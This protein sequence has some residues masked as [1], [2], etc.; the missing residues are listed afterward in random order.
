MK[1]LSTE[2]ME[3]AVKDFYDMAGRAAEHYGRL[4]EKMASQPT[5]AEDPA[6][7]VMTD[8]TEAF[9]ELG[10]A[11]VS[12]PEKIIA[13]QMDMLKQQQAL[14][15]QTALRFIVHLVG[16][17]SGAEQVQNFFTNLFEFHTEVHE[18]LRG[19]SILFAEQP[20]QE[21]LR[22]DVVVIEVPCFLDGIL[23]HLLGSRSLWKLAHRDH[24]RSRLDELLNF[25]AYL[26]EVDVKVLQDVGSYT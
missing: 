26:P 5:S 25:E 23:E 19:N 17:H 11:M 20:E 13:D 8:F 15:Q 22:A 6:A 24:L 16:V 18:Y 7:S 12:H 1:G 4:W 10:E 21:M 2:T 3:T 9:R 14:F